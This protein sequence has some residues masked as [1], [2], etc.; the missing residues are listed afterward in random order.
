MATSPAPSSQFRL[1]LDPSLRI[2]VAPSPLQVLRAFSQR[3]ERTVHRNGAMYLLKGRPSI[4]KRIAKHS[5][6]IG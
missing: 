5:T 2:P 3:C 4:K 6:L 1:L